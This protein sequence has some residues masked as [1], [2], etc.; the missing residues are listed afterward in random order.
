MAGRRDPPGSQLT[1]DEDPH[2]VARRTPLQKRPLA[3]AY[4]H[5]VVS[6]SCVR[7][8]KCGEA[9]IP[10]ARRPHLRKVWRMYVVAHYTAGIDRTTVEH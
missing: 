3:E 4:L 1:R 6:A 9:E 2:D 7:Q 10:L 5:Y 8:A